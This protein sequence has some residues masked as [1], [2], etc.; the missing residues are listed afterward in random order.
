MGYSWTIVEVSG[1]LPPVL[2]SPGETHYFLH[3]DRQNIFIDRVIPPNSCC[4][5]AAFGC[6]IQNMLAGVVNQARWQARAGAIVLACPAVPLPF[7][8][9]L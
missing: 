3:K 9:N 8:S 1:G 2:T 7:S 4:I 6:V 5:V